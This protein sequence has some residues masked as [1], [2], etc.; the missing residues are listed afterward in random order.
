MN[1]FDLSKNFIVMRDMM[2]DPDADQEATR[3]TLEAIDGAIED[4]ADGIA[5]V[6]KEI[7]AQAD[8]LKAEADRLKQKEAA[9]RNNKNRLRDYLL[10][11]MVSTDKTSFKTSHHSFSVRTSQSVDVIDENAIPEVY[12]KVSVS[13]AKKE[14]GDALKAGEEIAGA[15]LRVNRSVTIR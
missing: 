8:M 7:D 3:D 9:L 10:S 14:L 6:I 4:K 1:L 11:A 15:V 2:L 5:Y 13:V 12:K